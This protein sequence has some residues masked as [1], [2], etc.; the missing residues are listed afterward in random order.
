MTKLLRVFLALVALALLGTADAPA[1]VS[2]RPTLTRV[3]FLYGSVPPGTDPND[4]VRIGNT[5][6][7]GYAQ[8]AAM[9][10]TEQGHNLTELA[11]T[12]PAVNPLTL[13]RLVQYD[14][15]VL[16]SNN[17]R[18][19]SQEAAVIDD[20]LQ[21]G[22]ALF[23]FSDS[24]FGLS[25]D[26]GSNAL[27]AGELSDNDLLGQY[28]IS[29]QH[30]NYQV[31]V[32]DKSRFANPGHPVL[33]G[34]HSFKGE[35]VSLIHV[36]APP[37]QILVRG[38]GLLLTDGH[39]LTGLDYAITAVAQVGSGRVAVTFD[40]NTFFNAGVG[41]GG[42]DLDELDNRSYARNLFN[43]LARPRAPVPL[44]SCRSH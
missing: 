7:N 14:L 20:Y 35:G 25:P 1:W 39:T 6:R 32:A 28:G 23:A 10:L 8:L 5:G 15:L 30:D 29:V 19:S 31:V 42:T 41:S 27:G 2:A 3:L 40:R 13:G 24:R 21:R 12:D 9:L 44:A 34:L 43:W 17:R 33:A 18:F 36:T 38:D 22:G 4:M 37:A 11:D 26:R 16:G